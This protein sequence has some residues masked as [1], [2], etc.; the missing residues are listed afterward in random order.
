VSNTYEEEITETNLYGTKCTRIRR[1]KGLYDAARAS[2]PRLRGVSDHIIGH[3]L[4]TKGAT[5]DWP[6]R[7]RGWSFPRLAECRDAWCKD[8]PE[9]E[10]DEGSATDWEAE[11]ED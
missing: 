6:K 7:R 5:P 2:S 10:W 4:K 3:F 11:P 1:H 8:Y 9:T